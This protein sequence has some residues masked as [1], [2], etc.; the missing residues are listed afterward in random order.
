MRI[1]YLQSEVLE[2]IY[3]QSPDGHGS[4]YRDSIAAALGYPESSR[5]LER[6]LQMLL[7]KG[8]LEQSSDGGASY[9]LTPQAR[10]MLEETFDRWAD[11]QSSYDE[12][13]FLRDLMTVQ[14]PLASETLTQL[15]RQGV[16]HRWYTYLEDFPFEFTE[17]MLVRFGSGKDQLVLDP[18]CGSGT[19]L[20]TSKMLGL[21]AVGIDAN[22]LMAWVTRVKTN[23]NFDLDSL[24]ATIASLMVDL[25]LG[26][27]NLDNAKLTFDLRLVMPPRE[28]NSWLRPRLQKEI[29]LCKTLVDK[30]Q[31]E[32]ERALIAM[33]MGKS[34]FEASNVTLSPGTSFYPYRRKE[35]FFDLLCTRLVQIY[36]DLTALAALDNYG[37]V[38]VFCHD[39]RD[40][41]D[42]LS[43]ESVDFLLC[44]PPYPNDLE[45]TAQTRLELYLH[46]FVTSMSQVASM[47]K[48][49]VSGSTK[50]IWKD[51]RNERL[52]ADISEIRAV[53]ERM[54]SRL[55][56]KNWGFN[57]PR[58]MREF[59]GDM[60]LALERL[61]PI[62]KSGALSLW[63]VGD[64][65]IK[66][67][68]I[69]AP[70]LLGRVAERLGYI[71]VDTET[72]RVRRSTGQ[73]RHLKE[74]V[75]ILRRL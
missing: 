38:Q 31:N 71:V 3:R 69:P 29:S 55:A 32:S 70:R 74:Q 39:V 13:P 33:A 73:V 62:L 46:G 53:S 51:S 36:S 11:E 59:F 34:V 68:V 27:R 65:S 64:Q 43:G 58:M 12:K 2:F 6:H 49:M 18:F 42:F 50:L 26:L 60:H 8:S 24:R 37:E 47:K 21:N 1:P 4:I 63:V 54:A 16:V 28:L 66:G 56:D 75:V 44:S 48:R 19:T 61:R 20:V 10:Q 67:V 41:I 35:R 57:Y 52:V 22:P 14:L 23:W 9:R 7:K 40:P 30:V 72:L 5:L 25:A 45:Y 15:N 17:D